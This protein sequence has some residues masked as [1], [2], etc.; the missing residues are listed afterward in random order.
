MPEVD[1][2]LAGGQGRGEHLPALVFK[3][4]SGWRLG[5]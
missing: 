1:G 5:Q 2:E 4:L 3:A